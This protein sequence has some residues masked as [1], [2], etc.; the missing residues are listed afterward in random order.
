MNSIRH[1]FI[2]TPSFQHY[3]R[4]IQSFIGF[5]NFYCQFIGDFSKIARPLNLL[6]KKNVKFTWTNRCKL[7]FKR[8]KQRMCEAL[9]LQHFDLNKQCHMETNA[10]DYVSAKVLSQKNN[11]ILH[12]VAYF[13]RRMVLVKYNYEIYNKKLLAII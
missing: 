11:G 8:L 9:I 2:S 10:S 12:P 3:V 13:L 7:A 4:E 6:T 5:C 1:C